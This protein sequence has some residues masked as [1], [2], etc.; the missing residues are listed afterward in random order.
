MM[1]RYVHELT[2]AE[3]KFTQKL[4]KELLWRDERMVPA[5]EQILQVDS[6][7]TRVQL[8]SILS[9]INSEKAAHTLARRALYDPSPDVRDA[10]GYAL[11][12][13]PVGQFRRTLIDGFRYP[14]APVAQHAAE[15]LVAV[16]DQGAVGQLVDLLDEPNPARPHKGPAG[17]WVVKELVC[18]NHL[19][20]CVLCHAASPNRSDPVRGVIPTPGKPL[21]RAYYN[22]SRGTFV[23]ADVTYL[24]QDFSVP[25][26]VPKAHPWPGKQ[27]FDFFVRTRQVDEPGN[28]DSP[29]EPSYPQRDAV[30]FALQKL[31]G[32]NAGNSS[33]A[34]RRM[35]QENHPRF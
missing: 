12:A 7:D 20:S 6:T 15:T 26:E 32:K 29:D 21:P 4:E 5:L 11:A 27:R 9:Q 17:N 23:R 18:V 25:L 31:T 10:A 8:V 30:L 24:K 22:S 16:N 3:Y 14:W 2:E 13:R 33:E 1:S 34:W 35:V 28:Q 19:R